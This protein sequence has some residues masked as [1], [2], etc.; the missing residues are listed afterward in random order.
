MSLVFIPQ[1]KRVST[2]SSTLTLPKRPSIGLC[3]AGLMGI[4]ENLA[5]LFDRECEI[6]IS[7]RG[8]CDTLTLTIDAKCKP[9]GYRLSISSAGIVIAGDSPAGVRNG[10][11]T[12]AQ[13]ICQC[14]RSLPGLK[15]EDWPDLPARG[16]YYDVCRGRVPL[17]DRL[18]ELADGMAEYKLNELQL[19]IE[20]TFMFRRHPLIG[21][22]ADPLSA[23]DI[24]RLDR[25][26]IERGIELVPSLASFGHMHAVLRH[27]PYHGLA[28]DFGCLKYHPEA[29][30]EKPGLAN[31]AIAQSLA[32]ANPKVYDFL[33]GLFGE[34]LPCFTSDKFN[35]CCD[36]T[37]DLGCGQSY[38]LAK[39]IGHG[40][41][42]LG[43][44]KKLNT[45]SKK[46]GK[47]IQFW[48]DII[49][50]YPDLIKDIPKDVTV[51]DWAYHSGDDF[52]RLKDFTDTGLDTHVCP[53]VC[54]YVTLYPRVPESFDNIANWARAAV[55][56]GAS[57][58]LNTDWGDG[59]HYNFLEYSWPGYLFGAEQAWN[60][61]A[62]R[63]SFSARFCKLFLNTEDA[64]FRHA[65]DEMGEISHLGV[66][67]RYQS[68]WLHLFFAKPDDELFAR[69]KTK[70]SIVEKGAIVRCEIPW[71]AA[72]GRR[73]IKRLESIR[74][75]FSKQAGQRK[76][77]PR[78][79]L[80]YYVFA[81]DATI[82]AAR[83]L[84][85]LG[86]G[87]RNT[88]AGRKQLAA[89]MSALMERFEKLWMAR[90]R[91][92][93]IERTLSRYRGAIEALRS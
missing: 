46:Y 78:G 38:A 14:G 60:H 16:V 83:K 48:G 4:G 43:H 92:S 76:A 9:Q 19:Y 58:M 69:R 31:G 11:A 25:H 90:S 27:K 56:H 73:T 20:H 45:I 15:I 47:R 42:Y 88:T 26:C 50:H 61:K 79:I 41:L 1:P 52:K 40:R 63:K 72:L 55:K 64:G 93:E 18:F 13:V 24:M 81:I 7:A 62:D 68:A 66:A 91:R 80:P 51:L 82:H 57:G 2:V 37:W 28:E 32:P 74:K 87:G 21:S 8:I 23:A 17:L 30:K 75:V 49:R 89:E 54:S 71:N 6:A 53:S 70:A 3:S 86:H 65:L 39:K 33:D 77:D 35:V 44:I 10:A 12:L 22:G 5:A 36:E 67:G 29:L 84:A 85:L 59:G 34:F